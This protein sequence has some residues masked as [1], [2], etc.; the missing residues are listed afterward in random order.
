LYKEDL[1]L[2]VTFLLR[3]KC[4]IENCG[5]LGP[6]DD[7]GLGERDG[8]EDIYP[9]YPGDWNIADQQ[10]EVLEFVNIMLKSVRIFLS[11]RI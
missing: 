7:W 11:S 9:P 3:Q 6:D 8:T 4:W 5:E 2:T 1:Q 10:L